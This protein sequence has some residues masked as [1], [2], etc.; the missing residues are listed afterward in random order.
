MKQSR[1]ALDVK[2]ERVVQDALNNTMLNGTTVIVA[3][4]LTTVRNAHVIAV[5]HLGKIIVLITS[6][7]S[8]T[9]Q[10]FLH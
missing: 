7:M 8:P 3:H 1:S 4:R 5:V 10:S 9:S 2:S 6:Q